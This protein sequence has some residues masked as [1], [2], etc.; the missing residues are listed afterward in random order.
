M[1]LSEILVRY[2]QYAQNNNDMTEHMSTL[3]AYAARCAS[4]VEFG[5]RHCVSTWGLL[6]GQPVR[7]RSY[8]IERQPEVS[9]VEAT[10]CGTGIDFQFIL[11]SSLD[12]EIEETDLLFIDSLHTYDQLRQELVLHARK[13]RKFIILHD[14]TTFGDI[15]QFG[16]SPGLWCAVEEFLTLRGDWKLKERFTNCNGLTVLERS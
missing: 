12:V 14:T 5:V 10:V 7:M 3:R 15:D 16:G 11:G 6:A 2:E 13:V 1:S 4:V 8:D 9:E